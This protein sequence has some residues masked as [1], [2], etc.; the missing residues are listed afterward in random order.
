M[1]IR[2]LSRISHA[3]IKSYGAPRGKKSQI[4]V[5]ATLQRNRLGDFK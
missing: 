4:H 2:S 5:T 1:I 3:E